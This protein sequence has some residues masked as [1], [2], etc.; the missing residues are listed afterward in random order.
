ME[1]EE[2]TTSEESVENTEANEAQTQTEVA[3][4]DKFGG[5][6]DKAYKSYEEA[7][8][9]ARRTAQDLHQVRAELEQI[10]NANRQPDVDPDEQFAGLVKKSPYN[11]VRAVANETVS[12]TQRRLAAVE[13]EL[14]QAKLKNE[15]EDYDEMRPRMRELFNSYAH[16]INPQN[17]ND[18]AYLE[19]LYLKAKAER[20]NTGIEKVKQAAKREERVANTAKNKAFMEGSTPTTKA[21][22]FASLSLAEMEK[23]IG[24]ATR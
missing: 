14:A 2:M 6:Y 15:Y 22:D 9:Y 24:L 18:P 12:E 8:A 13:L 21:D 7:E 11:A 17:P 20:G 19:F 3:R 10:R 1:T 4:Q 23:Q 16:L 5:D